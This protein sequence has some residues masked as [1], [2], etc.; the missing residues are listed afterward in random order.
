[1]PITAPDSRL[2]VVVGILRNSR[3]QFL[4]QQRLEGKPCAGKWE[5]P[6]GKLEKG[7]SPAQGLKREILE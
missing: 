6:G 3:G 2:Y 5:F 1:M 7:E 4:V